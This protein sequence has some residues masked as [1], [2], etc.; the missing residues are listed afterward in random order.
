MAIRLTLSKNLSLAAVSLL[1]MAEVLLA[2]YQCS[3][4]PRPVDRPAASHNFSGSL[5][6]RRGLSQAKQSREPGPNADPAYAR[7]PDVYRQKCP[8][9]DDDHGDV[10][11]Y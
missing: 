7:R 5:G 4:W 6:L 2:V 3:R 8:A 10:Q 11:N 1:T 9:T